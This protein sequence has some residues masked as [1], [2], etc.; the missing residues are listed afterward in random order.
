MIQELWENV[1][2][3]EYSVCDTEHTLSIESVIVFGLRQD[4]FIHTIFF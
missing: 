4:F 3:S 1:A 2:P